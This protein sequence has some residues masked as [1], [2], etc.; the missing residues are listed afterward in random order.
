MYSVKL[1][2]TKIGFEISEGWC[3]CGGRRGVVDGV[4]VAAGCDES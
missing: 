4:G 2:L 3:R 1:S